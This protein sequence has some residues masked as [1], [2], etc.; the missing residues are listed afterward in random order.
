GTLG[1][2]AAVALALGLAGQL[3]PLRRWLPPVGLALMLV[4]GLGWYVLAGL[5]HPGFL[6][7]TVVDNH[8]LNAAGERHFSRQDLAL[9]RGEVLLVF[10]PR[11][12]PGLVGAGGGGRVLRRRPA[13]AGAA[14]A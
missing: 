11:A 2:L 6:W 14:G 9:G 5:R 10:R 8:V 4:L 13:W 12:F 7:Y 1:P 3:R